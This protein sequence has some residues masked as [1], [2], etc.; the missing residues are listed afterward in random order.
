MVQWDSN[1]PKFDSVGDNVE[2]VE[3]LG[4]DIVRIT[5]LRYPNGSDE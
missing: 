5:I 1:D 4:C 2:L 3:D